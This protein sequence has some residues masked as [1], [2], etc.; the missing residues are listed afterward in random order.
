MMV[1]EAVDPNTQEIPVAQTVE[2]H[3]ASE[4]SSVHAQQPERQAQSDKSIEDSKRFKQVYHKWKNTERENDELKNKLSEIDQKIAELSKRQES[5]VNESESD[6]L[7]KEY[8]DA[9]SRGDNAK[10]AKVNAEYLKLMARTEAQ[11]AQN[12]PQ[13]YGYAPQQPYQQQAYQA[14]PQHQD[15]RYVAQVAIFE[16]TNP[17]YGSDPTLTG[18]MDANLAFIN[19]NPQYSHLS[20]AAKLTE[21]VNRVKRDLQHKFSTSP[22]PASSVGGVGNGT[23]A[24]ATSQN[25][26]RKLTDDEQKFAL[27]FYSEVSPELALQRY[28]AALK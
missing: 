25:N 12:Q 3:E 19:S 27:E 17:W 15:P 24:A 4:P 2:Q 7:E 10:A 8:Q 13:Q 1:D 16:Q 14:Q 22:A 18:A 28:S 20:F 6:R 9:I 21:A 5:V 26:T 23:P 11:K